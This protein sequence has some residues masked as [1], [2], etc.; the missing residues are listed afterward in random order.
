MTGTQLP[1][2]DYTG[3]S[4]EDLR[5]RL[6]LA[7]EA[8]SRHM[9]D[10][11]WQ[12]MLAL[13]A[14]GYFLA[15]RNCPYDETDVAAMLDKQ[16][17]SVVV[18]QDKREWLGQTAERKRDPRYC[19]T[20]TTALASRH[21]VFKVTI[22]KDAQNDRNMHEQAAREMGMHAWIV[23]YH[24]GRVCRLAPY[25]RWRHLIRTWHT[26]DKDV[27]P[28][29]DP[30]GRKGCLLSGA[31]GSKVYPLRTRL[32]SYWRGIPELSVMTHPGY[33]ERGSSTPDYLKALSKFKVAICTASIY[34]YAL[35]KII[36]ATAAG[37]IVVTDLPHDDKLPYIEGNLAR[38][39]PNATTQEVGRVVQACLDDYTPDLQEHYQREALAFYDYRAMGVRLTN[40]IETL[41]QRYTP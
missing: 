3:P 18:V 31:L 5:P 24:P 34:G 12:L 26:V 6:A 32:A 10:E 7:N 22:V 15:G 4:K 11:S 30:R 37:C 36:E 9:T 29:Y 2:P 14:G 38:V 39:S 21:D 25:L 28:A 40:D 17:P 35:R 19:F 41:R 8:G 16:N 1:A 27:V 33:H 20:N 13:Q 23:Y